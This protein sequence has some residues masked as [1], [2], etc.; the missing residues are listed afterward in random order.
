M[1]DFVV[2]GAGLVG[3][4][5]AMYWAGPATAWSARAAS[6]P[7]RGAV[8]AG[9]SI[10]LAISARGLHALGQVGLRDAVLALR[11]AAPGSDDPPVRGTDGLPAVRDS[12][13][14]DQLVSRR[15]STS[16]C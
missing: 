15:R 8:E 7:R 5:M 11:H 3:S 14:G 2:V 16:S 12:R 6:G 4:L 13:T 9:R 10:N 1:N